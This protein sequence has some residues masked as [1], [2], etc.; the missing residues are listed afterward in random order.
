MTKYRIKHYLIIASL[1]CFI[2]CSTAICSTTIVFA[3]NTTSAITNK[4]IEDSYDSIVNIQKQ[5][6]AILKQYFHHLVDDTSPKPSTSLLDIYS[7]Q[8]N[9]ISPKLEDIVSSNA[10]ESQKT[11][12]Q[13][14]ISAI[15]YLK[16]AINDIRTLLTSSD[17][18]RQ[19]T[20]F[21][22]IIYLDSLLTEIL[23]YF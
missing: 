21:R 9:E 1:L 5:L 8:L 13:I 16:P 18:E 12:S 15:H 20:L 6:S 17:Y 7:N 4:T 22:S 3:Q 10:S 23:A 11:K 14:L 19:Y 2:I